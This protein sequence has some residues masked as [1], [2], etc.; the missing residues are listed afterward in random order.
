VNC[1]SGIELRQSW[2]DGFLCVCFDVILPKQSIH[3]CVSIEDDSSAFAGTTIGILVNHKE[4][5]RLWT[6]GVQIFGIRILILPKVLQLKDKHFDIS[7]SVLFG[8]WN[9]ELGIF[10]VKEVTKPHR[11][12]PS[13][14][15][16]E[17][18]GEG[19]QKR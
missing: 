6:Q 15:M 14:L 13:P 8:S 12:V 5:L 1:I 7:I 3:Y 9:L 4:T 18:Q 2:F 16:G 17:G 10:A 19:V 11:L